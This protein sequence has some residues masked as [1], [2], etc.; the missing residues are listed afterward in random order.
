MTGEPTNPCSTADGAQPTLGPDNDPR[1]RRL[2]TRA[3]PRVDR[4]RVDARGMATRLM[5]DS[6]WLGDR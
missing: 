3:E 4:S 2:L 1:K 6:D 5:R